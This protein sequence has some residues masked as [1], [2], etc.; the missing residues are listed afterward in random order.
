[1]IV[2]ALSRRQAGHLPLFTGILVIF[3]GTLVIFALLGFLY[4]VRWWALNNVGAY[5][6][7]RGPSGECLLVDT[8]DAHTVATY[9]PVYGKCGGRALAHWR[10]AHWW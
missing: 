3:A 9:A 10:I 7:V 4:C 6:V 5:V 1:M 2:A 8:D